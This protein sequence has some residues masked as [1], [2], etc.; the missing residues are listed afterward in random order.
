[1]L[2]LAPWTQVVNWMYIIRSEYVLDVSW[3]SCKFNLRLVPRGSLPFVYINSEFQR[4]KWLFCMLS[5]QI[6]KLFFKILRSKCTQNA[7]GLDWNQLLECFDYSPNHCR[8]F[9]GNLYNL[10]WIRYITQIELW[11]F[12]GTLPKDIQLFQE[13]LYRI[14]NSV[15]EIWKLNRKKQH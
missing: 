7:V 15:L 14:F 13:N 10:L 4:D 3:M 12:N 6:A 9:H 5:C 8:L 1:M 2:F 11:K